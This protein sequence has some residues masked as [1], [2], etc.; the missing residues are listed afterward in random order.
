[1]EIVFSDILRLLERLGFYFTIEHRRTSH[2][3][4]T[5]HTYDDESSRFYRIGV[6]SSSSLLT[7]SRSCILRRLLWDQLTQ[8][9][10]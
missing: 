6:T 1:M 7:E 3:Q 2:N 4:F 9:T 8:G 5:C 10:E